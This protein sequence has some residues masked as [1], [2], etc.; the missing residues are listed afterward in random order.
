MIE[1][2]EQNKKY[3]MLLLSLLIHLAFI[4]ALLRITETDKYLLEK[5][6]FAKHTPEDEPD[7]QLPQNQIAALKSRASNFGAPV[8]FH[9]EPEVQAHPGDQDGNDAN[10]DNG[11]IDEPE[12]TQEDETPAPEII[13]PMLKIPEEKAEP[14]MPE[15][16]QEPDPVPEEQPIEQKSS[17]IAKP[18][19]IPVAENTV[20]ESKPDESSPQEIKNDPEVITQATTIQEP[21]K[22][23]APEPAKP[24][25]PKP[26]P[27]VQKQ[28]L[29]MP[30]KRVVRK[31]AGQHKPGDS[32]RSASPVK[33]QLTLADLAE[34]FIN[35]L[36][37]G[38]QDWLDR[39]G[40]E[41]IRPDFKELKYQSYIQK[42]IWYMQ[43]EWR[44]TQG[45]LNTQVNGEYVLSVII[46]FL[47]DGKVGNVHVVQPSGYAHLDEFLV[48]GIRNAGPYPPLPNH[49]N[50]NTF[51]LPLN[52]LNGAEQ[53]K[54]WRMNL[55]SMA[56]RSRR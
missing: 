4:V 31:K 29:Q 49:F 26:Q 23:E 33:K 22:E 6:P 20:V 5:L 21:K 9:T 28:M 15:P 25:K 50:T 41:N 54:P 8:V 34:G 47:K 14:P 2:Q 12:I 42:V 55:S 36:N 16:T 32:S 7:L 37:R 10:T 52:I 51:D 40:N 30:K 18:L 27:T 17:S 35:T 19:T 39:E 1:R 53:N 56:S 44:A 43:N 48:R 24:E 3:Y 38:G 45:K 46:T 13:T 11:D